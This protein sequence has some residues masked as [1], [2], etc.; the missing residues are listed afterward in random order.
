MKLVILE[1]PDG[2]GKSTLAKKFVEQFGA[3]IC[4]HGPYIGDA[5]IA[6][7]YQWSLM[8]AI[9]GKR[10]IVMDRSWLSE[11]VYGP[12]MRGMNRI[13]Q[14]ERRAI[15]KMF[16][17]ANGIVVWCRPSL[18]T[19]EK[20]WQDRRG[21]EYVDGLDRFRKVYAAYETIEASSLLPSIRYNRDYDEPASMANAVRAMSRFLTLEK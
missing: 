8:R 12:I 20:C 17:R 4:R 2:G 18:A 3:R 16:R 1:G 21:I 6:S 13:T 10:L 15:E 14:L 19:C 11:F 7:H 5:E 9:H